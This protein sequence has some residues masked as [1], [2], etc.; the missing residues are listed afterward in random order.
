MDS[1]RIEGIRAY[2]GDYPLDMTYFTNRELNFIKTVS[3][4]RAGELEEAFSA[5]DNDLMVAIAGIAIWRKMGEKPNMDA[6]WDT[7]AGKFTF[8][9]EDTADEEDDDD[10]P[11][12]IAPDEPAT[13]GSGQPPVGE[14]LNGALALPASDLSRIGVQG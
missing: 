6:L 4:I 3:G 12:P 8:L 10:V 5:G 2:D 7:P 11:P 14:S 13:T 9:M 1:L